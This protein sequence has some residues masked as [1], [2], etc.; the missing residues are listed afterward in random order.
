MKKLTTLFLLIAVVGVSCNSRLSGLFEKKTPH[1]TYA[2]KLDDN[3]LDKTPEGR[4]WMAASGAALAHA[5]IV[6]LPYRQAGRFPAD[7]PRALG[8][9]FTARQGEKLNFT[10]QKDRNSNLPLYAD[11]FREENGE[12][13]HPQAAD[14]AS[15]QFSYVV[16][17]TASYVCNPSC[18]VRGNML[19]PF[20]LDPL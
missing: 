18:S 6:K 9:K 5:V 10:V 2:E 12:A 16:D 15:A 17:K 20:Q 1:E 14:T 13:I 19:S 8:L 4:Q 3:D 7:K 11:I